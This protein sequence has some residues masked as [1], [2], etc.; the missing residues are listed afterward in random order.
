M[1]TVGVRRRARP[2][3]G[4]F[5]RRV[6]V[7]L[8]LVTSATLTVEVLLTRIFDVLL[9]PNLS[10]MIISGAIFGLGL[11]GLYELLRGSR[12]RSGDDAL[13]GSALIL[14]IVVWLLPL[15]LNA[16]PFA[17][18]DFSEKPFVRLGSFLL[19]YV[20]LLAPFFF[21]GLCVCRIF[22]RYGRQAHRLYFWDLSGAAL[23]TLIVV[24]V[25]PVL[26]P[27][28]A[29]VGA[30]L[31]AVA[32]AGCLA[33]GRQWRAACGV[34]ALLLVTVPG[35]LGTAYEP[36]R[37]HDNKRDLAVAL[38]TGQLEVWRWDPVSHIAVVD[39]P[40][41]TAAPDDH[42]R[43]HIA[44]DGGS[45]TSDFFP[46]DGDLATLR[47]H[48]WQ[49]LPFQFW[50]RGVLAAHYL[51]RDTGATVLIIGSAGGQETKA[52]LLFGASHVDA[53]EMVGTVV[54][55]ATGR[56]AAYI[57]HLFQDARVAV[58]VDEGRTFLRA[59]RGQFDIIQIFS[60]YT[61]S[62]V[63]TGS[64]ALSPEYLETREANVEY[65]THLGPNGIL[66]V[67]H[68][69]YPRMIATMAAAW[70]S[71]GRT[72]FRSHVVVVEKQ[73]PALD[74]L[75]TILVKMSPWTSAEMADIRRFFTIVDGEDPYHV[76]EDPLNPA[77]S[78]L[79]DFFYSGVLPQSAAASAP[80]DMSVVTDDHPYFQF[81][82]RS[83]GRV[84]ADR[85]SGLNQST[86]DVLNAR[87]R[88][89][90]PLD[91][92]HL[93][94]GGIASLFYGVVF[95]VIPLTISRVGRQPWVGKTPV[96][97][98]FSLL[99]FGF[100]AI[101]LLLIQIWMKLIGYPLYSVVVVLS[102]M[103]IGAACGSLSA[104]RL[105]GHDG[106]RWGWVF[107]GVVGVGGAVLLLQPAISNAFIAA[108]AGTRIAVAAAATAPLAYFMGM[109]FPLG[110]RTLASKPD[111]AVAWAWSMSGLFTTIGA[112]LT[113][114]LSLWLGFRVTMAV[115]LAAYA[116]A[117]A[118][119]RQIRLGV[120]ERAEGAD[121]L[122]AKAE[123][124]YSQFVQEIQ[125]NVSD[126]NR[127]FVASANRRIVLETGDGRTVI[128]AGG[129]TT[130]IWLDPSRLQIN[131]ENGPA[132]E[133][134]TPIG[135][136]MD[137]YDRVRF[138]LYRNM[139]HAVG[140]VLHHVI[141]RLCA[142]KSGPTAPLGEPDRSAR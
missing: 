30:A 62:S 125:R 40:P 120:A 32:A 5:M 116:C 115:A 137:A 41:S 19:L 99:G 135:L 28:R 75:P 68:L 113:A 24:P 142:E 11:G 79:P 129:G 78:F 123:A 128:T 85:S 104:P 71:L 26:G 119:F 69:A 50:Q 84:Q 2:P 76:V 67:N 98:Y 108:G 96:L 55:L 134:S 15:L 101:E 14:A 107:G 91:W 95:I 59:S 27:S 133:A 127:T 131:Q 112:V 80:Y 72:A 103:L 44:Y 37:L 77:A 73:P 51:R 60:N 88:D 33:G 47:Q 12:T 54:A 53:V 1:H 118:T 81:L 31:A 83:L 56:Y 82:R 36:L 61:T 20:V 13:A 132:P 16:I 39:Q 122:N 46:F 66:Q 100:I 74:L 34:V 141:S 90:I 94:V 105:V 45:Q 48:L 64:G 21:A 58:H 7:G 29:L 86:A 136:G 38:R 42:G 117:A 89:G 3:R 130:R 22:A 63:A 6:Y 52:A 114:I 97:A 93:I 23:G 10:F 87:L 139:D 43:K 4:E 70:R 110:I 138:E 18:N 25:L 124:F 17:L 65:F 126:F 140:T 35:A 92:L 109:P 49:R 102:V 106:S 111:G 121:G 57:G 9:W 8:F